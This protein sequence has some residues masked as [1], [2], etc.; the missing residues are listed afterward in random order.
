METRVKICCMASVDEAHTAIRLGAAAVGLVSRMPS[1]PGPIE[2]ELIATIA[3]AVPRGVDTF[4]LTC[5]TRPTEIIAQQRRT[6][7]T[8]LQL[9]DR[10][11]DGAHRAL[12]EALP[13]TNI[14]QVI[15]VTGDDSFEEA[16]ALAPDVDALL[17]DSGNPSLPVKELGGT[18]RSHDWAISRRIVES[19]P[20]PVWLA[21]GLNASNVAEAIATVQPF[22]VDVCSGVRSGGR[23]DVEKLAAFMEKTRQTK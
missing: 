18:G 17:L 13:G 21:G 10:V 5:E 12:R 15:H 2:E 11:E 19:S 20:V 8:T 6:R 7:V 22:G 14:V 3:A 1:G 16:M 23:L 4:L 9:V